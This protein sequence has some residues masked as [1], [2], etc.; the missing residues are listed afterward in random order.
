MDAWD[1]AS[2]VKGE[3]SFKD[4][5]GCCFEE[6]R[7]GCRVGVE[8]RLVVRILLR[9]WRVWISARMERM[10]VSSSCSSGSGESS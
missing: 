8:R 7:R 4:E 6:L 3:R 5:R 9:C 2:F 10:S 1:V